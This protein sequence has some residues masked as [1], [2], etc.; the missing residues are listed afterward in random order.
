MMSVTVIFSI[1]FSFFEYK[2]KFDILQDEIKRG[3]SYLLNL[4]A[5]TKIK[6]ALSLDEIYISNGVGEITVK[7]K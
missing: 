5:K 6:T 3:N 1:P 2:K 4:T 7:F